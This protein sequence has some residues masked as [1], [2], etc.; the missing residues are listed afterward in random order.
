MR[1]EAPPRGR[2]PGRL[3]GRSACPRERRREAA[4]VGLVLA[5][6]LVDAAE[7]ASVRLL[8]VEG[9][10]L[11][12]RI[13]LGPWRPP[14]RV[15]WLRPP[16]R[17][18]PNGLP[19]PVRRA[20]RGTGGLR[21]RHTRLGCLG[22]RASK[23]LQML[24]ATGHVSPLITPSPGP[25]TPT[26]KHIQG[27]GLRRHLASLAAVPVQ[28]TRRCASQRPVR[29][30]RGPPRWRQ[31]FGRGCQHGQRCRRCGPTRL[32]ILPERVGRNEPVASEVAGPSRAV[33]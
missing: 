30:S 2:A 23:R 27:H 11:I 1:V 6:V 9:A 3:N 28:H 31:C 4:P 33:G 19:L 22:G 18:D 32:A 14:I 29:Q 26:I 10:A 17:A 13:P 12:A 8:H 21:T 15:C 16:T 20:Q 7:H 5:V 25:P 24:E